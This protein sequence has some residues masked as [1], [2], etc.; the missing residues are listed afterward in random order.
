MDSCE[1]D[2][3]ADSGEQEVRTVRSYEMSTWAF[4]SP[5]ALCGQRIP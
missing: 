5:M 2:V 4:G 3:L 1:A